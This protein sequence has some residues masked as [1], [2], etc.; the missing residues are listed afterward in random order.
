MIDCDLDSCW[1]QY[2]WIGDLVHLMGFED[3]IVQMTAEYAKIIV[4]IYL[5]RG[6]FDGYN[7]LLDVTGYVLF[8]CIFD[9]LYGLVDLVLL[10]ALCEY[11]DDVSLY[12]IGFY[13]MIV[14]IVF[15]TIL[16][17]IVSMKG[18]LNRFAEGMLWTFALSVSCLH[19]HHLFLL[20]LQ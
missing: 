20:F 13:E 17:A 6:F 19:Q 2:I 5:I 16:T 8:G 18:W 10:W 12:W 14:S 9:I 4:W 15:L 11:W 3:E 7:A 1:N